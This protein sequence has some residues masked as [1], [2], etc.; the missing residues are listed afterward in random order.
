MFNRWITGA[1]QLFHLQVVELIPARQA[2]SKEWAVEK[3]TY[4]ALGEPG[5]E[6]TALAEVSFDGQIASIEAALAARGWLPIS[7]LPS[8]KLSDFPYPCSF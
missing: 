4:N 3:Y 7:K 1:L 8:E 2:R 5:L 6:I